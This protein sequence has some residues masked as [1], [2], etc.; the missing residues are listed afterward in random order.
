LRFLL[1]QALPVRNDH[2]GGSN[3]SVI[4]QSVLEENDWLKNG[5]HQSPEVINELIEIMAHKLLRSVLS[6]ISSRIWFAIMADEIRDIS[7]HEQMV[8]CIRSVKSNYTVYEDMVGLCELDETT[9]SAIHSCLSDVLVRMNLMIKK[10]RGQAYDCA[11]SFQGH[12]NGVAK[13]LLKIIR[14]QFLFTV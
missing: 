8:V 14:Q 6:D 12:I 7:N 1:R 3:L 11:A 13:N 10:C 2:A 5:K 4:L 9:S